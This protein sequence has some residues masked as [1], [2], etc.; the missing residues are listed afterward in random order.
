MLTLPSQLIPLAITLDVIVFIATLF[1]HLARKHSNLVVLYVIQSLALALLLLAISFN[2]PA[3]NL[4]AAAIITILIKL[5]V[6]P[7]FFFRFLKKY[8][9]EFS[10]SN[11]TSLPVFLLTIALLTILS[12]QVIAPVIAIAASATVGPML[13]LALA[14]ILSGIFLMV[15]RRG[16]MGQLLGVL[17]LENSIVFLVSLLGIEH[18]FGL[19]LGIAFDTLVWMAIASTMLSVVYREFGSMDLSRLSDMKE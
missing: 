7:V 9:K 6:A 3:H 11:Y 1:M 12:Y 18:T 2:D 16:A 4:F 19:E 10:V 17:A 5:I 8:K 14:S 13:P 15:N